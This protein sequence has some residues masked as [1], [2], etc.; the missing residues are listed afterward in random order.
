VD[1]SCLVMFKTL[2]KNHLS[3]EHFGRSN[4]NRR[5][6]PLNHFGTEK[7]TAPEVRLIDFNIPI[8]CMVYI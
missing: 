4:G 2:L 8:L 1:V 5:E 7:G 3:E 6:A